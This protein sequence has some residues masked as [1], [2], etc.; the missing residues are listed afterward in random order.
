MSMADFT[1]SV[2]DALA[3]TAQFWEMVRRMK[4]RVLENRQLSDR[5]RIGTDTG[6][7]VSIESNRISYRSN[8]IVSA[9]VVSADI[10]CITAGSSTVDGSHY[11]R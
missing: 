11:T 5:Y 4:G 3:Q 1:Q 10:T 9:T 8:R 7:I 2:P 6:C